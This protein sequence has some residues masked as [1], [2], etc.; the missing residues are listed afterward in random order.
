MD[1]MGVGEPS[2]LG[3]VQEALAKVRTQDGG[4]DMDF[5]DILKRSF[6]KGRPG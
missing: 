6:P 4:L 3:Q 1:S 5:I 2:R